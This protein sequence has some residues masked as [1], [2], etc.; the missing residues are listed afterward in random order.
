[1]AQY[2]ITAGV[3]GKALA[4]TGKADIQSPSRWEFLNQSG[5]TGTNLNGSQIYVG[6]AGSV[7]VILADTVGA[8]DTVTSLSA[9][10]ITA[11]KDYFTN[12]GVATT[13]TSLV[14]KSPANQPSGL[15]VDITAELVTNIDTPGTGYTTG[16]Y[17][18]IGTGL[19]A[20]IIVV[21]GTGAI[22][23][24]TVTDFGDAQIGDTFDPTTLG[25]TGGLFRLTS[26]GGVTKAVVANAG[27]NY[28]VG[29]IITIVQAGTTS[30]ATFSVTSTGSLL[31]TAID[32]VVFAGVAQGAILPVAVDYVLNTGTAANLI[33]LR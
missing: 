11:G 16:S 29:D 12:F 8:Q 10:P 23:S 20:N 15:T 22:G 32:Q 25:G 1:M 3:F 7:A 27:T 31:P 5:I 18:D 30:D 26:F 19:V 6:T 14:H 17:S 28:S 13:V 9:D 24:V 33:A 2:P 21:G 4:V